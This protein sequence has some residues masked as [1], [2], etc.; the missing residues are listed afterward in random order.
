MNAKRYSVCETVV[1]QQV[2]EETVLL[3]LDSGTYYSLNGV[4]SAVWRGITDGLSI[5]ELVD[6]VLDRYDVS[7]EQA[8]TD[9][10]R[11]LDDDADLGL[12]ARA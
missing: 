4:A 5:P 12:L 10:E 8:A 1:A 2:G 9:V 6:A 11:L 7:R 3:E